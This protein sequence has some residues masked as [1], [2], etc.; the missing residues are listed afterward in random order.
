MQIEGRIIQILP[1]EQGVSK[2][3]GNPWSKATIVVE[4]TG[5]Y[6]KKV[7]MSNMKQA[8]EFAKLPIG[9]FAKF[10]IDVES[11]E[12]NGKWFTNC[13]CYRWETV[14][15]VE[16]QPQPV[17]TQPQYQQPAPQAQPI[18]PSQNVDLPF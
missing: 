1:L 17:Y 4:T 15:V 2:T 14:G 3:S 13:T 9:M 6:P 8:E 10:S 5:Q 7:A 18:P 12:Y 16:T 11:R